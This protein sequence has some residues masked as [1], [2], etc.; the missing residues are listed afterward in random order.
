MTQFTH[1]ELLVIEESL[2][3]SINAT[4]RYL[5]EEGK[6]ISG[7]K[8]EALLVRRRYLVDA[9]IK[10]GLSSAVEVVEEH[11]PITLFMQDGNGTLH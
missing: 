5:Q 8:K 1:N 6:K 7:I 11:K 2:E 10:L 4:D 3:N 9:L